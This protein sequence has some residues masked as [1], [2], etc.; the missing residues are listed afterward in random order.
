MNPGTLKETTLDPATP[1]A[2]AGARSRDAAADRAGD[3]DA[4]GPRRRAALRV[5]HGAR[6]AGRRGRRVKR[7][8]ITGLGGVTPI[9]IG[10]DAI[11]E[12]ACA[13]RSGIGPITLFDVSKQKCRIAGEVRGFDAGALDARQA[14]EAHGRLRA[15]RGGV[16]GHGGRGREAA[17]QR[18]EQRS[19]SACC[20][21]T[22]TAARAP[23]SA[24]SRSTTPRGP[25]RSRPST[26]RRSPPAWAPD[27]W[28]S[29]CGVRGPNFTIGNACASGLNGVGEAWRYIREGTCDAVLAGGTDALIDPDRDRRLRELARRL[30]AQR[31]ARA[32]QPSLRPRSRRLRALRRRR[33]CCV[34]EELEHARA[35]GARI[36]AE[37]VGYATRQRGVPHR[38]AAARR[39]SAS[40]PRMQAALESAG[41]RARGDR[42]RERARHL[43]ARS[44]TS[45]RPRASSWCSATTRAASRSAPPSR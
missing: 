43:H 37:I 15:L 38:G 21:A 36:Y 4:H 26:S 19:A 16:G 3:P 13:G 30:D 24:R 39:A 18:R 7:V 31:R 32:R 14:P 10:V 8:V 33:P 12:S 20:S 42:L 25:T 17:D 34:V 35:R 1:R 22:T 6:A 9:G 5:H 11:W 41:R 27:R 2:A 29:G 45:T 23:S 44:A 40:P 28:P